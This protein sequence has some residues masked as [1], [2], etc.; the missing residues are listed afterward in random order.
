M[1]RQLY[2]TLCFCIRNERPIYPFPLT[3]LEYRHVCGVRVEKYPSAFTPFLCYED[4][5]ATTSLD[6]LSRKEDSEDTFPLLR[7]RWSSSYDDGWHG[8]ALW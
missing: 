4:E 6:H 5:L 3:I 8:E 2:I 7:T 1:T